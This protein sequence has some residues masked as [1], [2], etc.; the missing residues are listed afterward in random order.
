MSVSSRLR[1]AVTFARPNAG[2]PP[3]LPADADARLTE[4][5][6]AQF[7][8][9]SN[10]DQRHLLAVYE[11][12]R[13]SE[14]DDDTVT[15]GLIH[16]VGKACRRCSHNVAQRTAHVM[17]N[18]ILPVPYRRF[19]AMEHVPDALWSMQV[20]ANHAERGA[21]AAAQQGYSD[22]VCELIRTHESGGRDDDPA[23]RLLRDADDRAV[24][25]G[26]RS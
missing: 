20:L 4:Q 19:A 5:M 1:Q 25:E 2:H 11:Y 15:A 3:V 6:H 14:A 21:K 16:D 7:R 13:A 9:L 18:R 24:Y 10:A 17:L 8:I 12:L 26:P 22:R 23:L